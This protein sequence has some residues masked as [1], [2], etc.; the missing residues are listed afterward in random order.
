MELLSTS[1]FVEAPF[2]IATFGDYTFGSYTSKTNSV[3]MGKTMKVSYPNMMKSLEVVKI[4]GDV[5]TY[6]LRLKYAITEHDDPNMMEKLFSSIK[7]NREI[8]LTYGDWNNPSSIYRKETALITSIKSNM[9]MSSSSIEYTVSGVSNSVTLNA[10]IYDFPARRAKPS[11]IIKEVLY[12]PSYGLL[13]TFT[14]MTNKYVVNNKNLIASDD[15]V[16]DIKSQSMSALDYLIYL[17]ENMTNMSESNDAMVKQSMYQLCI[18]DDSS[19][20]MN[21][22]YFKVKSIDS[23]QNIKSLES[24]W[25]VDVGYPGKNFVTNFEIENDESY[26]ILYGYQ[27]KINQS[28]YVYRIDNDGNLTMESSPSLM[29]S[30]K[31]KSVAETSKTWWTQMTQF[32][33][34]AKLT[35]KGLVRPTILMDYIKLNV[36][37]YGQKHISSGVYA[38]TKQ[39]DS[40]SSSGYRTTL[41]LVRVEGDG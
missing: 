35:I 13:T 2:V 29:R 18:V 12:T 41:S 3:L 31:N 27:D 9:S 11:D 20:E 39:V 25:E 19:N 38:I 28:Q 24:G 34:K 36:L 40:I 6:T 5:N 7:N 10:A 37:F 14:G 21:G 23:R 15:K 32:P 30:T 4:N 1:N 17:V 26:S 8:T 16:V 22:P 33:I